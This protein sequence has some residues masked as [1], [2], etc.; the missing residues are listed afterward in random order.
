MWAVGETCWRL[1]NH[2]GCAII[3]HT[4]TNYTRANPDAFNTLLT[5]LR[6]Y[7][8][9]CRSPPAPPSNCGGGN[10]RK[11]PFCPTPRSSL[12]E[13]QWHATD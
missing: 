6:A 2:P 10:A 7:S 4:F 11:C 12:Q 3:S 13:R 8:S 1:H 5:L 9:S